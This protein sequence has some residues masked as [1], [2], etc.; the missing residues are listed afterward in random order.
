MMFTY[1]D[2]WSFCVISKPP[3]RRVA[4]RR[5]V[6]KLS[7][8]IFFF[9]PPTRRVAACRDRVTKTFVVDYQRDS[10]AY[11]V[12]ACRNVT[13]LSIKI[14]FFNPPTR[15]VA[16]CRNVTKLRANATRAYRRVAACRNVTKLSIKIIFSI[17]PLVGS[18]HAATG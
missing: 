12:A 6:T 3:S 2:E 10:I 11:P 9:N 4:A 8:K 17:H 7:I 14:F 16:A 18:R 13:K 1:G 5:N 15:R